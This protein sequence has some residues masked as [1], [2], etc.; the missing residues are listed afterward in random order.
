MR[1]EET[2]VGKLGK[3]RRPVIY[4]YGAFKFD[5]VRPVYALIYMR[6]SITQGKGV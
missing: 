6:L 1:K 4:F 5:I 3:L 2:D